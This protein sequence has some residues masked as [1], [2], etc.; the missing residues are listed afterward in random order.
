MLTGEGS[1]SKY[2]TRVVELPSALASR[3][4]AVFLDANIPSGA[5]VK[6]WYR[7]SLL[8]EA[9]IFVKPWIELPRTD[10]GFSSTSEI[11][12]REAAYRTAANVTDF[13][14]YQIRVELIP[15]SG[16]TYYKTPAVRSVRV[17]SFI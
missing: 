5:N 13:K 12:F 10:S 8:G 7:A 16:A 1:T 15:P 3:G 4:L 6:V 17:V 14:S 11:D 2:L 9:D